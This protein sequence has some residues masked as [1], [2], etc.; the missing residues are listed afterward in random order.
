[1]SRAYE[2]TPSGPHEPRVSDPVR[3][4]LRRSGA[5]Y[6][7]VGQGLRGLVENWERVV[8]Q[9]MA[10]YDEPLDSYLNEMEGRQLLANA[11][12]LAPSDVRDAFLPRVRDAD[13]KIR[14]NLVRAGRCLWGNIVAEDEEWTE[15]KNWWYYEHPRSPGPRLRQDLLLG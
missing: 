8:Q 15:E 6:S 2:S 12:E 4:Y 5:P 13:L 7:V 11:L 9:V 10:G 3:E 1:M 14:L